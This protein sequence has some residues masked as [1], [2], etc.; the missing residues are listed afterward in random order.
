MMGFIF[1][2]VLLV[3]CALLGKALFGAVGAGIFAAI[4]TLIWMVGAWEVK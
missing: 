3:L 4:Y 2:L 1:N